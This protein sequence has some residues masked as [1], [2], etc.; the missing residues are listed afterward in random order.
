MQENNPDFKSDRW[1]KMIRV[2]VNGAQ[3]KMGQVAVKAISED[4]A[5][6]LCGTGTR[7]DD[8]VD[9]IQFSGAQ[10]V[11]DFT[12]ASSVFENVQKIIGLNKY[13]VIGTSGLLPE[14]IQFLQ[15]ACHAKKI[16][17][18]IVPNFSIGAVLMMRYAQAIASY[19]AAVEIIEMH[20]DKKQDAPSGTALRTAEMIAEG[21]GS[22]SI[23]EVAREVIA[24]SRGARVCGIPIHAIRLP[25][26]LAHQQVIFGGPGETLT[27]RH[28]T[29]DRGCFMP[30]LLL[31]CKKVMALETLQIG[32]EC[33]L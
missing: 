4:A 15:S 24:G 32:L 25:G 17:G 30:G 23:A 12:T 9:R 21:G 11:V 7:G 2:F 27:L 6:Q 22:Y 28:D 33:I 20:H 19:Y 3:G 8:L 14:Q 10:V 29:V 5:L 31:A 16:G 18:I 26:L 13:P 1:E